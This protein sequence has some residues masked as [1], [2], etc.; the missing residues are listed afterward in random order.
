MSKAE[1]GAAVGRG[2]RPLS[3][4]LQV[5]KPQLHSAMSI[6]NRITGVGN[7]L[8]AVL[9]TWWFVAMAAGPDAFATANGFLTS[10]FG[11][12]LL[13]GFA[14]SVCY[15]L[16]NGVRHLFWDAGYGFEKEQVR[17]SGFIVIGTAVFFALSLLIIGW[18]Y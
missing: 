10:W 13:I 14:F 8:G 17:I 12:L 1:H 15:H 11:I 18:A 7:V 2:A 5:Y 16:C 9:V 3:P 4:H 6:F